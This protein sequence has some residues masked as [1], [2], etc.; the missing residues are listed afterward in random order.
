MKALKQDQEISFEGSQ[1]H[2]SLGMIDWS[3]VAKVQE[4]MQKTGMVHT[5]CC[6]Q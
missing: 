5:N 6:H 4:A 1:G 2:G 3:I